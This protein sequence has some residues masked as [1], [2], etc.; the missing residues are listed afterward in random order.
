MIVELHKHSGA[1]IKRYLALSSDEKPTKDIFKGSELIE[2]DTS[3][4]FIFANGNWIQIDRCRSHW[5][6]KLAKQQ[7]WLETVTYGIEDEEDYIGTILK[8]INHVH[9]LVRLTGNNTAEFVSTPVFAGNTSSKYMLEA[10]S[11]QIPFEPPAENP[12]FKTVFS[13]TK[14]SYYLNTWSVPVYAE[15]TNNQCTIDGVQ[16]SF[17]DVAVGDTYQFVAG[18]SWHTAETGMRSHIAEL[19]ICASEGG[20]AT[21]APFR[22]NMYAND[23]FVWGTDANKNGPV[24]KFWQLPFY[25]R[26]DG[27][28]K[29]FEIR[30]A[31]F[32]AGVIERI[33]LIMKGWDE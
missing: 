25:A 18:G 30:L 14:S 31:E 10:I 3:D 20:D 28:N 7:V 8:P 19:Y 11:V 24:D 13:Y 2:I 4:E 21:P 22:V 16:L 1:N 32:Q 9:S 15:I 12:G 26:E 29:T 17:N 27:L 33:T 5:D 6:I 23:A